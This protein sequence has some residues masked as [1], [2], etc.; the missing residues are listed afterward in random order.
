MASYVQHLPIAATLCMYMSQASNESSVPDELFVFDYFPKCMTE[1]LHAKIKEI[2]SS[3]Y[4]ACDFLF[5]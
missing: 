1:I 4:F 3:C 5:F 2:F